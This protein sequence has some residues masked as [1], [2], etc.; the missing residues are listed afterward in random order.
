[1]NGMKIE[2]GRNSQSSFMRILLEGEIQKTEE[3][4]LSRNN[5]EGLLETMWQKEDSEYVLRYT[6]TGKQALDAMLESVIVDE[7]LLINLIQ[8]ICSLCR[9]LEKFLLSQDGLM[10]EPEMIYWDARKENFYFCYYPGE[11]GRLQDK[12]IRLMEYLLTKTDHK[13][14]RAVEMVYGVYETLLHDGN[15][16]NEILKSLEKI[17]K[18]WKN[19]E[20]EKESGNDIGRIETL[21]VKEKL[22][23]GH[24][25]DVIKRVV[26]WVNH[27]MNAWIKPELYNKLNWKKKKDEFVFEP[28]E[29]PEKTITPTILLS[30]EKQCIQ[31]MLR[32]EGG[33]LLKDIYISKLPFLIGSDVGC[34]GIIDDATVSRKHAM[35]TKV[36][37]VYF[38]EDMNSSN[39]TMVEGE[40]ISYKTKISIKKNDVIQFSNQ[41]YR[42]I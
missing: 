18:S 19:A 33:S 14:V 11:N 3:A 39:G 24:E 7:C 25:C 21:D 31:G 40:F 10:L 26:G 20:E 38:I 34:D 4:M 32:Y 12:F 16:V 8:E 5:I 13:N 15:N 22:Q 28:E 37:E 36:D 1:M 23:E 27:K 29:E 41:R 2:Y 42:F 17:R 6:I 30:T 9:R 35:I